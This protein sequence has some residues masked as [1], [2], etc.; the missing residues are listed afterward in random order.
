MDYITANHSKHYLMAHII[1]VCKYRKRLLSYMGDTVKLMIVEVSHNHGWGII[2]QEIDQDHIHILI[3]YP[4]TDS[5]VKIV[6]TLK[7]ITTYRIWRNPK[8]QLI[9]QRN[10]WIEHT[11]WSD[12]YFASS[13]GQVSQDTIERYIREQG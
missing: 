8:Y 11:F 4:P 7:Q 10:F 5:I 1:F 9:L 6:R 13:I 12:G 2:E 3:R